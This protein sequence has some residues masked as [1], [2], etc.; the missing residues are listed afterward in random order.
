MI[1]FLS[2][3]IHL[4]QAVLLIFIE[5]D[6]SGNQKHNPQP[7]HQKPKTRSKER[8]QSSLN[9]SGAQMQKRK[10]EREIEKEIEKEN[11][12]LNINMLLSNPSAWE[13]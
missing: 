3:L 8:H 12:A 6:K 1:L 13:F 9:I 2:V 11:P 4:Q 7:L 10:R 5:T